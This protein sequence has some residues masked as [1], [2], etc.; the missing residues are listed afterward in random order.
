[1][2]RLLTVICVGALGLQAQP[3]SA[4]LPFEVV[5]LQPHEAFVSGVAWKIRGSEITLATYSVSDLIAESYGLK[6]YQMSGVTD[7]LAPDWM[8]I[9]RFDIVLRAT[10]G[11]VPT[12]D[13]VRVMLRVVL[14][15]QF[16]F[17]SHLESRQ[18]PVYALLVAPGGVKLKDSSAVL[19][20]SSVTSKGRTTTMTFSGAPLEKLVAELPGIAGVDRPVLDK[21]ALTGRYD[22]Q[23]VRT[24]TD[25]DVT[26]IF[27][28][29]PDQLGLKLEAQVSAISVL[30]IDHAEKPT[31]K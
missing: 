20:S 30:V 15:E 24:A 10:G 31:P 21:T 9:A 13:Q 8:K 27:A 22:F 4:A 11:V 17:K 19:P 28:N 25:S 16:H 12:P 26:A 7:S 5:S 3:Q 14:A 29:L 6:D 23:L 18:M 2:K 1:M